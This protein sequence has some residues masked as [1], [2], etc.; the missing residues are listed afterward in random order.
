MLYLGMDLLTLFKLDGLR[1]STTLVDI[2]NI[3]VMSPLCYR[4]RQSKP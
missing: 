3:E 4:V 2:T 1:G